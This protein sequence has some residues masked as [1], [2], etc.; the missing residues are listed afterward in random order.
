MSTDLQRTDVRIHGLNSLRALASIAVLTTHV[1]F[2]TYLTAGHGIWSFLLARLD[3]GVAIFFALSGFLLSRPFLGAIRDRRPAPDTLNY[4]WKRCLRI[5]PPYWVAVLMGLLL[6]GENV[7]RDLGA[8]VWVSF[9]SLTSI[10]VDVPGPAGLTQMWSLC[11]E[12]SFYA[13]LPLLAWV[14][15]RTVCRD[16]WRPAVLLAL[17]PVVVAVNIAWYFTVFHFPAPY[18][19][20]SMLWLPGYASWFAAGFA[21]AVIS[22]CAP[23][24]RTIAGR[25]RRAC[26]TAAASP[27]LCW[28]LIGL[29]YLLAAT[30]LTGP[31]LFSTVLTDWNLVTKNLL[32]MVVAGGMLIPTVFARDDDP[33]HRVMSSRPLSH[34]GEL[35][36]GVFCYHVIVLYFTFGALGVPLFQGHFWMVWTTCLV[37]SLALAQVS[38]SLM[39]KPL[40]RYRSLVSGR[41]R[42]TSGGTSAKHRATSAK[43]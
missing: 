9:L 37:A 29:T 13:V 15:A 35:S 33:L 3:I 41:P 40:L 24:G 25:A 26:E 30:P 16:R 19:R 36:Y 31:E 2:Q 14:T 17:A 8:D 42:S 20:L 34:L 7:R 1:G 11:V 4:V 32:F 38:Y 10:Y 27:G 5:L 21:V 28:L 23:D 39:E 18:S 6:I 43:T 22:L 12:G